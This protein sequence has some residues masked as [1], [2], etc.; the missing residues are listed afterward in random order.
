V[1]KLGSEAVGAIILAV[2]G[3]LIITAFIQFGNSQPV[4]VRYQD[5][6]PHGWG[7]TSEKPAAQV[8]P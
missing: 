6:S 7:F 4:P 3:V 8:K 2:L 1:R 5:T